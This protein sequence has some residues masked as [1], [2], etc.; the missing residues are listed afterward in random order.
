MK[1]VPVWIDTDTGV[2]DAVA[3]LTAV[4]LEKEGFFEIRGVSAV[5]GNAELERT[6]ENARNVLS[7][8][9]REDIPVFPGARKP[10][11]TELS[12]A[13]EAH[14][15]DGL[16]GAE[17]P[18]SKAVRE[19]VPAWDAIYRCAKECKGE[20]QLVLLGP[21]TNAAIALQKYRDLPSCL[22][23][24][25]IMGGAD[26]G[27]NR[28]PAAEFNIYADA[29]AAQTVFKSG[30]PVVMC[31]LD[32]TMKANLTR[33]EMEDLDTFDSKGC[34]LFRE[35]SQVTRR[36]YEKLEGVKNYYVHD[37][38]PVLFAACPDMFYGE[39]AGVFVETRGKLTFGKTV[40]DRDT[41]IKFGVK[42]TFVVLDLD[43]D[44]FAQAVIKAL[45]AV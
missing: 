15:A 44:R 4:Q 28:T 11:M 6:F 19:E 16:G 18:S 23:R 40:S 43:R 39:E 25:L 3:L 14:G 37:A 20:L 41:D 38:C 7:L 2:D 10:L 21:E 33:E 13:P 5:C 30:I 32:V 22:K 1:K 42:N 8:A 36:L 45:K 35:S 27:G 24:I 17:I 12:T 34:R 29:Y 26:V 31:G 9:G